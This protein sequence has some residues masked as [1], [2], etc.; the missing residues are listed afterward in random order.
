M[1]LK[2]RLPS[3]LFWLIMLA[4]ASVF[5]CYLSVWKQWRPFLVS[6]LFYIAAAYVR[7]FLEAG[8]RIHNDTALDQTRIALAAAMLVLG[9]LTMV[10][11]WK[12]PEWVGRL[13]LDRWSRDR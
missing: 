4:A 8:K 7:A 10:L 5:T 6:G 9:I 1:D 11:A 12:L 3:W 13:R 2:H